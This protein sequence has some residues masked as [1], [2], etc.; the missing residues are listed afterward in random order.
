M[1]E[2]CR[3]QVRDTTSTRSLSE[4]SNHREASLIFLKSNEISLKIA[5]M[6]RLTGSLGGN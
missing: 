6:S 5:S 4:N 1:A 3:Q 2:G